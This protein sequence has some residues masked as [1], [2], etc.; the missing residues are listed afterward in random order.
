MTKVLITGANGQLGSDIVL[1]MQQAGYDT[2]G[3]THQDIDVGNLMQV[4]KVLMYYNPHIVINTAAFHHVDQCETD[5][6]Q[7]TLINATSPAFMARM[8]RYFNMQLIH[9][10]TDYVFGGDKSSPYLET[11]V[12]VPLNVY[13]KSKREGELKIQAEGAQHLILR[14][15][16]LYGKK[17]CRAKSG[18]NFIQLMLKLAREKGEV[19]VVDDEFVS[20]TST[21][22]VAAILP[23]LIQRELQGIVHL[24][25]E[26]HCSWHDFAHEIFSYCQTDVK[27]N[28]ATSA[29]FISKTPRPK[30]SV[31]EN[32]ILH[33]NGI[34]DM[35]HWKDALHEYLNQLTDKII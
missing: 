20:P 11:D 12:T 6:K 24:T 1:A 22:N 5:H 31:L 3:L 14:V 7:A 9:F 10:S 30:Y 16:A 21:G 17:P 35:K 13:G 2:I 26:G 33:H 8:C 34:R 23:T 19:K 18:L 15:S 25:S 29:D 32:A 4:K 27:L 28:R